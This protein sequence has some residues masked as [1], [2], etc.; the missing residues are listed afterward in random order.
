MRLF[1]HKALHEDHVIWGEWRSVTTDSSEVLLDQLKGWDYQQDLHLQVECQLNVAAACQDLDVQADEIV[2]L[3]TVDCRSTA[4]RFIG[5]TRP[6]STAKLRQVESDYED[7]ESWS[8]AGG[9]YYLGYWEDGGTWAVTDTADIVL[10]EAVS[11]DGAL[12]ALRRIDSEASESW[13]NLT[14]SV[15]IPRESV[16]KRLEM[17]VQFIVV[18]R[19]SDG[20]GLGARLLVGPTKGTQ[21]EGD[22][23]R[24]PTEPVSFKAMGWG[25]ALWKVRLSFDSPEDAFAG[26]VRLFVNVDH[27]GASSLLDPQAPSGHVIRAFLRQDIVRV[28]LSALAREARVG[29]AVIAPQDDEDAASVVGV[30]NTL[31]REWLKSDVDEAIALLERS[32]EDFDTN[33]QATALDLGKRVFS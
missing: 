9:L 5:S 13:Q 21:L 2:F 28:V 30:A 12:D 33:L 16:A 1:P 26:A 29:S 4:R 7:W 27:P 15:T 24:F 18:S 8:G 31:S 10:K 22:G 19:A 11:R 32:P 20:H 23:A 14:C 6:T 17:A 3:A 25:P